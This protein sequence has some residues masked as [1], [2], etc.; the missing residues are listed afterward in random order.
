MKKQ[1]LILCMLGTFVG[2]TQSAEAPKK[3]IEELGIVTYE[4]QQFDLDQLNES[5]KK[6]YRRLQ[7]TLVKLSQQE[8]IDGWEAFFSDKKPIG[9]EKVFSELKDYTKKSFNPATWQ[10]PVSNQTIGKVTLQTSPAPTPAPK[11]KM[12]PA[13]MPRKHS[14]Q[15]AT[16]EAL[17]QSKA[18]AVVFSTPPAATIDDD[19]DF[20]DIAEQARLTEIAKREVELA[21]MVRLLA[22]Q[23]ALELARRLAEEEE[24]RQVALT[25]AEESERLERESKEED[26]REAARLETIRQAT[27]DQEIAEAKQLEEVQKL[28]REQKIKD[29]EEKDQRID[30]S[31]K[32]IAQAKEA[33]R[34]IKWE[35]KLAESAKQQDQELVLKQVR[36]KI[37]AQLSDPSSYE[38]TIA[39]V[40]GFSNLSIKTQQYLTPSIYRQGSIEY[41]IAI[42]ALSQIVNYFYGIETYGYSTAKLGDRHCNNFKSVLYDFSEMYK[43]TKEQAHVL[44]LTP[45]TNHFNVQIKDLTKDT[46]L[47]SII[48][49]TIEAIVELSEQFAKTASAHALLTFEDVLPG[50]PTQGVVAEVTALHPEDRRLAATDDHDLSL[51]IYT[52][53]KEG[54]LKHIL[55]HQASDQLIKEWSPIFAKIIEFINMQDSFFNRA[56]S[57]KDYSDFITKINLPSLIQ[58]MRF[59][60]G[61]NPDNYTNPTKS[62]SPSSLQI[63]LNKLGIPEQYFDYINGFI[64]ETK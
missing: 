11:P 63:F 32:K 18:S 31:D 41:A 10:A 9:Q 37:I 24:A 21:D 46:R 35:K 60:L 51:K 1:F 19:F 34:R 6:A 62:M 44:P 40:P 43:M 12:P 47:Q 22:E 17:A 15:K 64:E 42:I 13:V 55:R 28:A 59:L 27:R 49:P 53:S 45:F 2:K 14:E 48:T 30:F 54:A 25:L 58:S 33:I 20:R 50:R 39:S 29:L 38:A 4:D 3:S 16:E 23:E 61:E 8:Q 26:A 5:Q 56:I 52:D 7:R 57:K 36:E